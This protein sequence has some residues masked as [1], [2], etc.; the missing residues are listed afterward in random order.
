MCSGLPIAFFGLGAEDHFDSIEV[1]WP[2][3]WSKEEFTSK[4]LDGG[5]VDRSIVLRKREH[6]TP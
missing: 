3:D 1:T 5:T 2:D 4:E 6:H